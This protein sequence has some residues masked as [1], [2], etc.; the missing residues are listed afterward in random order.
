MLGQSTS[1]MLRDMGA[2]CAFHP[3]TST[4]VLPALLVASYTIPSTRMVNPITE[5]A[6]RTLP[7][8]T[9]VPRTRS[10]HTSNPMISMPSTTP[11]YRRS[12]IDHA[13]TTVL[14]SIAFQQKRGFKA[15]PAAFRND[16]V[17]PWPAPYHSCPSTEP[18]CKDNFFSCPVDTSSGLAENNCPTWDAKRRICVPKAKAEEKRRWWKNRLIDL[19]CIFVPGGVLLGLI[20]FFGWLSSD[21]VQP[22]TNAKHNHF[23]AEQPA[24]R[25]SSPAAPTHQRSANKE[26]GRIFDVA[27]VVVLGT[28]LASAVH[29][30]VLI[31]VRNGL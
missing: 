15:V 9:N 17:Y 29:F 28:V 19:S 20:L 30:L 25:P 3:A 5:T 10:Y 21:I 18:P 12:T 8:R 6:A 24:K 1:L 27:K 31:V 16:T 11:S 4:K 23:A 2:L 22:Q 7:F 26:T 14:S 13:P